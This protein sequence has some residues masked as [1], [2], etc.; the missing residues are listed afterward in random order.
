VYY[1]NH[2]QLEY[3]F[4]I[5]PGA[6][7][8]RIQFEIKGASKIGLDK[9]G[10]LVLRLGNGEI[11]FQNPIVYQDFKG[12]RTRVR[13]AYVITD[14]THIA[15]RLA[16]Y[17]P[18]VPLV[19]DPVLV[20]STYL[21]G[22]G[23]DQP[24][25][26]AVDGTGSVYIAGYTNSLNFPLAAF[27][28]LKTTTWMQN[29]STPFI[30]Q[31]PPPHVFVAKLDPA[32]ANLVYADY[33]GGNSEDYAF[34]LVLDSAN[35]VYVTGSTASSN[36]PVV[37]AYQS[38]QPGPYS[39]F[40]TKVS[41]DGSSVLY[42]T[43]L[44][45]NTYDQ[46]A[47]IA[48][49]GF[50]QVHV[51][52][53]TASQNFPVVNPYQASVSANQAG[54]YGEY[55]FLTKFSADGSSL[56]YSTYLAGNSNVAQTC[57]SGSCWP[58]PN[59]AIAALAVDG[60]DNAYVAGT[61]NTYNFPVTPGAFLT[62]NTTQ[63]DASIGFVSKF[64]SAGG[65]DYSTYFY[66]SSGN[67]VGITAIAVDNSGS[68]YIT[69]TAQSDG[70]FPITSTG[71]CDPGVDGL[72]CGYAFVTKFDP[73][74]STLLYSTFLGPN[75]YASPEAIALDATG[76]AYLL[77]STSSSLF[78]TD[79]A[80][81][82][83]TSN[84]DLLLV[85]ID[86]AATTQLFSTYLGGSG[87]DG[88]SGIALDAVDDIYIAGSTDS[89]DLPITQGAFQDQIGGNIDAFVMKIGQGSVPTASLT[90]S[91][92]Q[93]AQQP[94]GSTSQA[95]QVEFRDM[96]SL[97]LAVAS[98]SVT[99]DFAETDN[100]GTGIPAA[101]NCTLSVTFT[102]TGAGVRTGS[103]VIKD[104]A[105]GS[106]HL[107]TL[108]GSAVGPVVALTPASLAFA[109]TPI[110]ISSKAQSATLANQGNVSLNISSIQV[111][112]DFTQTNNCPAV[113]AAGTD[114]TLNITFT[115]T[116]AGNRSGTLTITD[117][118]FGSPHTVTLSGSGSDFSLSSSPTSVTVE[119]GHT[120]TYTLTVA[121]VGGA[122][123]NAINLACSGSPAYSTCS[124][125]PASVTPGSKSATATLTIRTTSSSAEALLLP[126]FG[127]ELVCAAWM[128]LSG[129]GLFG[130]MVAGSKRW[131]K[132]ALVPIAQALVIAALLFLSA[133]AG[134]TGIGRQKTPPGTYT[135]TVTGTS[136]ALSHSLP[137]TLIVN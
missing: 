6:D 22:T 55:G 121:P 72:S 17:D 90:P 82:G 69:G 108:N 24:A 36:F 13:G 118:A 110:G 57:G 45:G 78:Q 98:I 123:T 86:P 95:Q 131:R 68:A 127:Q 135:V 9:T 35:E 38:Q 84:Q 94:V 21:G 119:S 47:S 132:K 52:G 65:L 122:F 126:P 23:M 120:A 49:D 74:G 28:S 114:C 8:R 67:P 133:C 30:A 1:G 56:V 125:S 80:I 106:P 87:N 91:A 117:D 112:G 26:I 113:L 76:N 100:C 54:I 41:A 66:A 62:S 124:F 15:F 50:G 81:E 44:G 60:N 58:A 71:I 137:L 46:P 73:T 77:T 32:G 37:K 88:P 128:Q 2:Q 59:S 61:T 85:E 39:G 34:A 12:Q 25:G 53:Y 96:S 75:N 134:G 19:I 16:H 92:L 33:I 105:G 103:I 130:L 31:P 115:P 20:Y 11:H 107:V 102:P 64:G 42:S 48:I 29:G 63:Q 129:F 111:T 79:Q 10:N 7:P 104:N 89:S 3:D 97:P 4:E 18:S 83:Y 70:T 109:S 14:S 101:G 116:V 136:G 5:Q 27:G 40:L 99:G 43:Y 93:F 51:V